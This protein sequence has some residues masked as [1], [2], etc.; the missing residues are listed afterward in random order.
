MSCVVKCPAFVTRVFG[1]CRPRRRFR[2]PPRIRELMSGLVGRGGELSSSSSSETGD[3]SKPNDDVFSIIV[4]Y[5]SHAQNRKRISN[6]VNGR[7]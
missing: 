2:R 3:C 7:P 6:D 5:L 4:C 1:D